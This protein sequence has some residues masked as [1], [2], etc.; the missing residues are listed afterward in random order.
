M[1]GYYPKRRLI[2]RRMGKS[3]CAYVEEASK[4]GISQA[5]MAQE[6]G[7]QAITLGKWLEREGYE[8]AAAYVKT[9]EAAA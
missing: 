3:F 5:Q 2:E 7:V 9:T 4:R 6:L 1:R 8:K